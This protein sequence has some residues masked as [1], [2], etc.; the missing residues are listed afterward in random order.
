MWIPARPRRSRS[1]LDPGP[2]VLPDLTVTAKAAKPVEFAW[3]TKYD[4][5]FRRRNYGFPGG[6]FISADDIKRRSALHTVELLEQYV[7][8]ARVYVHYVGAGGTEIKFPRCGDGYVA[9]W[10]DGRKV[11]WQPE[12]QQASQVSVLSLS[13]GATGPVTQ[14]SRQRG[15]QLADVLDDISPS[16]IQFMEVYRG[17]GSIPGEFSGALGR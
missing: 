16:Q 9:V 6:T 12:H 3:T 17:I 13:K 11:N 10:L 1:C 2:Q 15:T 4:D 8:G 14:R 7:P 5:F